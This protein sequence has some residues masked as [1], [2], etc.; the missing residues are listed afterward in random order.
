MCLTSGERVQCHVSHQVS[1]VQMYCVKQTN[2][3]ADWR[4]QLFLSLYVSVSDFITDCA[5]LGESVPGFVK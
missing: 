2:K 4:E 3:Q 5:M 1:E